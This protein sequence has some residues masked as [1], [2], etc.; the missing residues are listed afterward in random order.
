MA[1]LFLKSK[2]LSLKSMIDV[3]HYKHNNILNYTEA[4]LNVHV[5]NTY[6]QRN[7]H[8]GMLS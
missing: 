7:I 5:V 2:E 4:S 6:F 1:L 3:K 8:Y